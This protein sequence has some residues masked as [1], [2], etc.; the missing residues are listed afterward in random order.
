MLRLMFHEIAPFAQILYLFCPTAPQFCPTAPQ[1]QLEYTK[2]HST[3]PIIP[4]LKLPKH[5]HERP[6]NNYDIEY[7]A[8]DLKLPKHI[9]ERPSNNNDIEYQ[10][11]D[12][13][14]T[15]PHFCPKAPH[16]TLESCCCLTPGPN[17]W[18]AHDGMPIAGYSNVDQANGA[19]VGSRE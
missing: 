11:T 3:S 5:I 12:I 7:Q 6:S 8:T 2:N 17:Y 15:M 4:T 14:L 9:H 19:K 10:A 13:K 16:T 18:T 1:Q